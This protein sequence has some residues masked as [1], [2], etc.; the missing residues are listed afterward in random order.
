MPDRPFV[1]EFTAEERE[2]LL[3]YFTNVDRPV[4]AL[5]NLPEIVKGGL[6]ARYSRTGKSLRR[7]FLDEF[8]AGEDLGAVEETGSKKASELYD[9]IF[10]EYGDDSVAQLGGAHVAVE[11][12][13][14]LLTKILERGR[15]AG[16]LE[17]STRYVPYA[18]KPGGR[19]R[20]HLPTE[21]I[22]AGL[23]SRYREV[24]DRLFDRYAEAIP[25]MTAGYEARFPKQSDDTKLVYTQTIRAKTLDAIRGMLPAA[26]TSNTGIYAAGQSLEGLLLRMQASPLAEARETAALMLTELREVIPSFLVRVDQPERGIAWSRYLASIRED[27]AGVVGDLTAKDEPEDRP[28]VTL[29]AFDPD[30]ETEVLA[31]LL[32]E[33]SDLP[34]DQA[35]R[36][37]AGLS[38]EERRRLLEAATGARENRRH[39]PGRAF[40]RTGY[41]FDILSD[42]GA[43]RDLQRHRLLTIEW[44]KLS[45]TFG[46]EV[47]ADVAAFGC[48][49]LFA[50]SLRESASLHTE[51]LEACGADA[52]QYA[53]C[54]AY[55]IRYAIQLNARAAMHLIELRSSPQG[56]AAYRA[57]AHEMHRLI[58]EEAGHHALAA[59]MTHVD[60]SEVDLERLDAERRADRR[61]REAGRA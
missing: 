17:Q 43:F 59:S 50:T 52:A 2:V 19:Y 61:R 1:E 46:A 44:Q 33:A 31:G 41:R 11:Q 56:H 7:L 40:E 4:F 34:D 38:S 42:Y 55:R 36:I 6:F 57:I 29:T 21:I 20:Y 48:E 51:L 53:V 13:S 54:M 12:G 23:A 49:E 27:V 15:L 60:R 9:R 24:M 47:S 30:G 22:D 14:N 3:R 28:V 58:D 45:P 8:Y 37:A 16:Y 10:I 35:R 25:L 26:V 18:D 39:K 5:R 32:Y